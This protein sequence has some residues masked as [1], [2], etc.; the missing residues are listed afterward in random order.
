MHNIINLDELQN[1]TL[2]VNEICDKIIHALHQSANKCLPKCKFNKN[3][4]PYWS[5]E[6]KNAHIVV[7]RKRKS[8]INTG[9]PRGRD[10]ITYSEYK[11][12]KNTFRNLQRSESEKYNTKVFDELDEAAGLDYKIFWKLLRSRKKGKCEN[13]VQDISYKNITYKDES[14]PKGFAAYFTDVFNNTNDP[15]NVRF[16][17]HIK[18]SLA[19]VNKNELVSPFSH[20]LESPFTT[21]EISKVVKLLKRRKSSSHDNILNEHLIYGGNLIAHALEILF[22]K[23]LANE[24]SPSSW[25][26]S[27]IIPIYKGNG[28]SKSDPTSYR[29]ISLIPCF[30][31]LFEK[32][33][34]DRSYAF[35]KASQIMFPCIQQQGFQKGYSCTTAAFNLQESIYY[36][37][38]N[39]GSPYVAFLDIKAAFDGVWH[40]ALFLKLSKLGIRG[41]IC[42]IITESYGQ[43]SCSIKCNGRLSSQVSITRGVRQGGVLS[44]FLYLVFIDELLLLLQRSESSLLAYTVRCGNPT[45][46]DDICIIATSPNNLQQLIDI[47]Y[48]ICN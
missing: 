6:L 43:M 25:S 38:E 34:L 29:P 17:N 26:H 12:A 20:I 36:I 33:L 42:R 11:T 48:K 9:K 27:I 2:D 44:T 30:A 24:C 3:A 37:V 19:S 16:V 28:K 4:K 41:K 8:W 22:N 14:I 13:I 1:S 39:G 18:S 15:E 31:K 47:V 10:F 32:L 23:I 46:A 45:L 35:L 40:D 21:S 5:N 7:K